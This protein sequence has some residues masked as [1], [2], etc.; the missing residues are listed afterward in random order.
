M[1]L[2][3]EKLEKEHDRHFF[4]SLNNQ[5]FDL[6][7]LKKLL[8][9]HEMK[10]IKH[11][12][13]KEKI[14]FG[15]L[16]ISVR[17]PHG[18]PDLDPAL[19][20]TFCNMLQDRS[21][22]YFWP[23]IQLKTCEIK[24][25]AVDR[26]VSDLI[27]YR[28][29][30]LLN[31][32]N[33]DIFVFYYN[34]VSD[35]TD[36]A[37]GIQNRHGNAT[38]KKIIFA[39]NVGK[40]NDETYVGNTVV[41]EKVVSGC[42]F[43]MGIYNTAENELFYGDSQ[44]W[45]MPQSV[46]Q[47]LQE[48]LSLIFGRE[49]SEATVFSNCHIP[50]KGDII[51]SCSKNCW[52]YYPLQTCTHI[53]GISAII[54]M[55][56]AASP[57]DYFHSLKGTTDKVIRGFD[58]LKNI[59][60][61][62]DFLRL[63]VMQWLLT[64]KIEI[65]ALRCAH[66]VNHPEKSKPGG[67]EDETLTIAVCEEYK[68][69]CF[70]GEHTDMC[71]PYYASEQ[72][73]CKKDTI[74]SRINNYIQI[75]T[76]QGVRKCSLVDKHYHCSL[77]PPWK[78]FQSLY[79][80]NRHIRQTHVNP[81]RTFKYDGF[82]I[83]PC[84]QEHDNMKYSGSRYHYHCPLCNKTVLQKSFFE[85]H[86]KIHKY[87]IKAM[88]SVPNS[89]NSDISTRTEE[90]TQL[91]PHTEFT[92]D[93]Q[94]REAEP[95]TAD[96]NENEDVNNL[97]QLNESDPI[98]SSMKIKR[99]LNPV[100][101]CNQCGKSILKKNLKRHS[102]T[103]HNSIMI[104][105]V[106]CD[107]ERGLY[108][109]RK[110][111]KGG[112][113][114]PVHVQKIL[115]SSKSTSVECGDLKCRLEMQLAGR[116]KMTARECKHLLQVNNASY[117]DRINL[118]DNKIHELGQ[119]NRFKILKN[120]T[121]TECIEINRQAIQKN[122]PTVVQ[123]QDGN[124]IHMSIFDFNTQ[125]RP[126]LMRRI[127]SFNKEKGQL[128]CQCAQNC[129]FCIHRAMGLWFLYQTSQLP[130]SAEVYENVNT[131]DHISSDDEDNDPK[132]PK[133]MTFGN[134]VY[135]PREGNALTKMCNYLK[136]Y[137]QIPVTVPP[138]LTSISNESIPKAFI[139][140]ENQCH[141]CKNKLKGPFLLS[142]NAKILT[143]NGMLYGY[144][145]FIK[146]CPN[147]QMYY[148]Y[149]EYSD[150]VHNFND[151]FLISL[152]V[153]V[154]LRE[155]VKQHVAVGTVC[156]I[157]EE[158]LHVK[159]KQQTVLNAYMHFVALSAH[160]YDFNCVICGFHPPI[161]IADLNR[162]VVFKCRTID[163]DIQKSDADMADYVDCEEFWDKV[164]INVLMKGFVIST[165][166]DLAIK[167]SIHNWSPYMGRCTRSSNFLVNTEH[168]KIHKDTGELEADCRELSQERLMEF[169]HKGKAV[170][171]RKIARKVGVSDKGSKLD[172]INRVQ[173]A[174]HRNKTKFN[175]LF[176]KLWGCSGG[177]LTMTCTH[178]IIYGV[179]FLLRS[180]SPRDYIDML[181]NMKHR[182]NVLVCD[183]AHMVAALGNRYEDDFFKPFQGRVAES[184]SENIE[185]AKSGSLSVSFPFLEDN[186]P[187]KLELSDSD[188]HPVTGSNVRLALFDVFHQSNTNSDVESL[189]RIGCVRELKGNLNSQAAEQ[190]HHSFNKDKHFLNQMS[191]VNH[192]FMFRSIIEQRNE[193][194]NLKI[195]DKMREQT[196]AALAFDQF[197]RGYL[198]NYEGPRIQYE[199]AFKISCD[200]REDNSD[201]DSSSSLFSEKDAGCKNNAPVDCNSNSVSGAS[202]MKKQRQATVSHPSFTFDYDTENSNVWIEDLGLTYADKHLI[203]YG[204]NVNAAIINASSRLIRQENNIIEG[205]LPIVEPGGYKGNGG[206]FVQIF[207]VSENHWI[208]MSNVFTDYGNVSVYDSAMRLNY[209]WE[210][211]EIRYDVAIELDA[212][213]LRCLPH[214]NMMLYVEDTMQVKKDADSGIAAI[215]F[216]LAIARGRDPQTI[217]FNYKLM[218]KK[219]IECLSNSNFNSI[220]FDDS[221]RR[222]WKRKFE[223][224]VALFCHCNKPDMG[225]PMTICGTCAKWYHMSCEDGDFRSDDWKCRNCSGTIDIPN[226][227][228][229]HDSIS[230][231]SESSDEQESIVSSWKHLVNKL[232]KEY[233]NSCPKVDL[234][235]FKRFVRQS[236]KEA[237]LHNL[238]EN[239]EVDFPK[240]TSMSGMNNPS[241]Q[242]IC[243]YNSTAYENAF[244]VINRLIIEKHP[245]Q[246]VLGKRGAD[247]AMLVAAKVLQR[248]FEHIEP[249]SG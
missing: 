5:H 42:H 17:Q 174:L 111:Q 244:Q 60:N 86:M 68:Q 248:Y 234:N 39:V 233:D 102:V 220:T 167:P 84:K 197:G 93:E 149:Q 67:G 114:Y 180:E 154:F 187:A 143:M 221:P 38:P 219:L 239:M 215:M 45:P 113:G 223:F 80:I 63:I 57:E 140:I 104:T 249:S 242:L 78:H 98:T 30:E 205:L 94:L 208:T 207:K 156:D 211:K 33:P 192:I 107:Q 97:T 88:K 90:T 44:G 166:V 195:C 147:C 35:I 196:R 204:F 36:I 89:L 3:L 217:N 23:S 21:E 142:K 232:G 236:L 173:R 76:S 95:K 164:E 64:G 224:S 61:Y 120:E 127:V 109:V 225:D 183:M 135:P 54:S 10:D 246:F 170:E 179:K 231:L 218:R 112:I 163:D 172:I 227:L 103:A 29:I 168:R 18:T 124:Y 122:A 191:P 186:T 177:W 184:N 34:F 28:I 27:L 175:K 96:I 155:N 202:P 169:M 126:V 110:N 75:C 105:A 237:W 77:C 25:L 66:T 150:G 48:L 24:R 194:K 20:S 7:A 134:F 132:P 157:L 121:I 58:Y 85:K 214:P 59:S 136:K 50:H 165:P 226:K 206:L 56:L 72:S 8:L 238:I 65:S 1:I 151:R 243:K 198:S 51:H 159:L 123:W 241:I 228:D 133:P 144:A 53:C 209:R 141:E 116:A 115:H 108:M 106:C 41:G 171:I 222:Q 125:I 137:K 193:A 70:S 161:L 229:R 31:D 182:P 210:S 230:D 91:P 12:V 52:R 128:D 62:S 83:L 148:R 201:T 131:D 74:A 190:L 81:V 117:P 73:E 26:W 162:K 6:A 199:N 240:I 69:E 119:D 13:Q 19:V 235:T 189:R 46:L 160:S 118:L 92:N 87:K 152:D 129:Y 181:R 32:S 213:N 4:A 153:C 79:R 15:K 14:W 101:S 145:T 130:S 2:H 55:C 100:V 37:R 49:T 9:L 247:K 22:G 139:P 40:W 188:S 178:G 200:S 71:T 99:A 146:I 203:D 185:N 176:K 158:Y 138:H 47:N 43:S 11:E 212:C 16:A 216:A 82:R 245:S